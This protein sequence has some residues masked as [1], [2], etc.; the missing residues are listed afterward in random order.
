[1]PTFL[2][3]ARCMVV[4]QPDLAAP[5]SE[6]V[7]SDTKKIKKSFITMMMKDDGKRKFKQNTQDY[8]AIDSGR[9]CEN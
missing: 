9:I 8:F 1:M 5:H 4:G 7:G 3:S 6:L 2:S